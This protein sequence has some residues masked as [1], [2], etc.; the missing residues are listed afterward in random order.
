MFKSHKQGYPLR[1]VTTACGTSIE[2]LSA[3]TEYYLS[4]LAR[5]HPAYIKYTTH[6]L[7]KRQKI[8]EQSVFPPRTLLITCD[9]EDMFPNIDTKLG[10]KAVRK[11]LNSGTD[12]F[13]STQCILSTVELCLKYNH[14]YFEGEQYIQREGMAM[15]PKSTCSYAD[16]GVGTRGYFLPLP[17]AA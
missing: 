17:D 16:M 9:V 14:S 10:L 13:P 11:T 15:G 4:P 7:T 8:R 3:F 12:K 1:V 2:N 5:Q 6:L